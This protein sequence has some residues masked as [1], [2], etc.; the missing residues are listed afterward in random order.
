M[1]VKKLRDEAVSRALGNI[2]QIEEA[3]GVGYD[4]L[5]KIRSELIELASD[6]SLF[7]R[8][9]F[10]VSDSGESFVY[11]LSE[12]DDH[13]FA[14][15]GSVGTSGKEVFPHNHTTW[16][17]IVGVHGQE[18]NL[19]YERT[20]D[21]SVPGKAVL[22]ETGDFVVT[23]GNGVVFMPD[24]IHSISTED[25]ESTL[26]LHMYGMA[27]DHLHHRLVFDREA[28]SVSTMPIRNEI[29]DPLG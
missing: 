8:A 11:R 5:K 2:R 17:V 29:Q 28:Q 12:D 26:H 18:F 15:Y 13:R 3:M 23:H 7:P 10:P 24:D 6:K 1:S 19:F 27:L 25:A 21:R 20:D 16:A 4:S 9:H 14:L 22:K